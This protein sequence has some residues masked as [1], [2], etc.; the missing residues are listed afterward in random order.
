MRKVLIVGGGQS[1]MQLALCL[2]E[3]AYDVTLMTVCSAE[4][5]FGGRAVS[6][7]ILYHSACAAERE[8]G[9]D[10]WEGRLPPINGMRI[11]GHLPGGATAFDWTG[12]L[13]APAQSIDERVKMAVWQQEFEERG[14][15]VVLHGATVSDLDRLTGMFDLTI[16]ATGHSGLAEMFEAD[17]SRPLAR[18][19][20][21]ATAIAYLEASAAYPDADVV[22][23]DIV[24][25][26]G[27]V[28]AW[29]G[30]SVNGPCHQIA[31][32]GAA[33]GPLSRFPRRLTPQAHLAVLLDL[34]REYLPERYAAYRGAVLADPGAVAMD[35]ANPLVR[36]PV[37]LLPSGR[38]VLG[39]GDTVVV[40]S[41]ALQ[42]DANNASM[43]AKV[44]LEAILAHGGAPFDESFMH[45]AF[46]RYMEY[47]GP[48]TSEVAARLHFNPPYVVDFC[49]AADRHQVLADRFVNGFD[50]PAG[51]ATWFA[52]ED[53]TRR[54]VA[55]CEHA[56]AGRA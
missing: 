24:P 48:F 15:K 6:M 55:E 20:K 36:R 52:D 11:T 22:G 45:A 51:L 12:R 41:P 16:V 32:T 54:M 44:Y 53:A 39:M 17:G 34:L 2:Q 4:E 35:H 23:V 13:D 50:D 40:T 30:Y 42:Q 19:P 49:T 31:V 14:G 38:P 56:T 1:G 21:V 25:G 18:M 29:P 26:L 37:A 3:H 46:E 47:A 8:Y 5:L 28:I 33:D 9:L 27:H 7:Q 10:F 43:A